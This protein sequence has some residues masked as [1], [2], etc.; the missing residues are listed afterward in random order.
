MKRTTLITLTLALF[1]FCAQAQRIIP[2]KDAL[3]HIGKKVKI[4]DKVFGEN[5]KKGV[6]TL[7]LGADHPDELITV[8]IKADFKT[9][10]KGHFEN[11][12]HFDDYY[13]GKDICVTGVVQKDKYTGKATI[14]V[15]QPSQIK[16]FMEDSMP[17]QAPSL[18]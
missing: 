8:V 1:S 4:C 17:Q 10:L 18:H 14:R 12:S 16:P 11:N 5:I 2:A 7:Y 9:N 6:T 13:R 15:T 3:K